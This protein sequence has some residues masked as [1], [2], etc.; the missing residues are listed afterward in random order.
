MK[1]FRMLAA[2]IAGWALAGP[3]LA[4]SAPDEVGT[5]DGVLKGVVSGEVVSFKDIPYAAP[6]LGDL[7]WRAPQPVVPWRGARPAADYGPGCIQTDGAGLYRGPTSEDC[8]T[9]NVFAPARRDDVKHPVMVWIHGGGFIGGSAARYDGTHFAEDGVVL[10]TLNYRLGRLGFFAHP[11]LAR[12]SPDGSLADFGLMDQIAALKWVKANIAAF[13]GDPDNVT[14]FGES[15]G[16]VSVDCLMASPLARGLFQKAIAESSF[17]RFAGH[18]LA[19][20]QQIGAAF[21]QAQRISGNDAAVAKAMRALPAS[22]FTAPI[23]SLAD[24]GA[25][26]PIVDGVVLTDPPA[27]TFAKGGQAKVPFIIGGNSFEASLFPETSQHPEAVLGR[28]G[29]YRDQAVQLY[30]GGDPVK[31]AANLVTEGQVIEPAR[32]LARQQAKAGQPAYLY[33][34]SYVPAA[35]RDQIM[36]AGHGAEVS[37]VFELLPKIAFER[38]ASDNRTGPRHI[39]AATPED[40]A[41]SRAMHAYWIAFAKTG[42]P[43]AAGGPAWP[44]AGAHDEVIEFGADGVNVRPDFEAMKLNLLA[45]RAERLAGGGD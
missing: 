29:A 36:G 23:V 13:G 8:L 35:L 34:F 43:G 27:E 45:A 17:G 9:L 2:V 7:R 20:T 26:G 44:V 15:A 1:L 18:P 38:P 16:G 33:Y 41:I 19:Q 24:A 4:Q 31:A 22:A 11:A 14:V 40:E 12:T 6:P 42:D 37:Y 3:A 5:H 39:P 28:L 10:V 32:Y 30:G 25:P 21:V